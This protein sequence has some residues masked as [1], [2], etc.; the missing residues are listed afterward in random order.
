MAGAFIGRAQELETLLRIVHGDGGPA[1]VALVTSPPGS[2]KSRLLSEVSARAEVA[3][4]VRLAGYRAGLKV[5]FAAV[6]PLLSRLADAGDDGKRLRE[7]VFERQSAAEGAVDPLRVFEAAHRAV[8]AQGATLIVLDDLQWADPLSV[9]L[10][11]YVLRGARDALHRVVLLGAS[12][13]GVT[14]TDFTDSAASVLPEGTVTVLELGGLGRDEGIEL[15]R[16]LAPHLPPADAETLW[17]KAA[18]SP[19]WIEALVR[20]GGVEADAAQLLDARL[21]D[22]SADA[23]SLLALLVV[24]GR[25]LMLAESAELQLW[26]LERAERAAEELTARGLVVRAGALQLAHDLIG[27]AVAAGLSQT[28]WLRLHRRL[29]EWL[30][31]AAEDHLQLLLEALEH[32]AAAGLPTLALASRVA[33]SPRRRF[34]GEE[35]L[36]QL[37]AI[38][39]DTALDDEQALTLTEDVAALAAELADHECALRLGLRIAER[40]TDPLR[41]SDDLLAA[42][43][44][45]FELGHAREANQLLERAE[46][47]AETDATLTLDVITGRAT[48]ALHLGRDLGEGRRLA[49]EA[50]SAALA[51][52][53][54]AGGVD[55][56]DLRGRQAYSAALGIGS[57]AAAQ[58]GDFDAALAAAEERVH[59]TRS[60]CEQTHLG[61][62]LALAM[63]RRSIDGIR[64]V[65]DEATRRVLPRLAFDAGVLLVQQLLTAGRLREADEAAHEAAKLRARVVDRPRNR[66]TLAYFECVIALYRRNFFEAL[67]VLEDEAA[68]ETRDHIRASFLL[69][70]AHWRARVL[71][72]TDA[73]ETLVSLANARATIQAL[74]FP[75]LSGQL[76]SLEGEVLARL[77]HVDEARQTLALWDVHH[78][79]RF[80]WD[81]L[82]RRA[83]GALASIH[84][85]DAAGGIAELEQ[86]AAGFEE[87]QMALEA[88]WTQI[89]LGRAL[90]QVDVGRAAETLS[91]ARAAA[92]RLGALT[93]Q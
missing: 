55:A 58:E 52:A 90:A 79:P 17:L 5:P 40:R 47:D 84:G 30:E 70:R 92:A 78:G 46:R 72:E 34:I 86:V 44:A 11:Q 21:R 6:A 39:D 16:S 45:A 73:D 91:D 53:E 24:A 43:K 71:G 88:V 76:S 28:A 81:T 56:L 35:G 57:E 42:A 25:P 74:N 60:L 19:F 1:A 51:L 41:R 15:V 93:L 8:E 13:P 32:Q 75:L 83:A 50:A 77:G 31:T 2:G 67:R 29:A 4:R 12:R 20:A 64:N 48:V 69:E 68:A 85:G 38:A 10:C 54:H 49:R 89:D 9:A 80:V 26:P 33:R 82:R 63:I 87:E 65:R 59:V 36:R 14:A 18:G 22:A 23:A 37:E 7:L 61:S 66:V 3:H 27:E 62:C